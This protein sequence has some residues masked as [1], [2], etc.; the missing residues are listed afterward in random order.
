MS[1]LAS[2]TMA[3][4]EKKEAKVTS[5]LQPESLKVIAESVGVASLPDEAASLLADDATYRLKLIL[6]V[7]V[8]N[9]IFIC[10]IER[11]DIVYQFSNSRGT[12][13]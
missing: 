7:E 9:Q 2:L 5:H 10:F 6:Q 11:N 3:E 13:F 4:K 1:R 8:G 12:Y